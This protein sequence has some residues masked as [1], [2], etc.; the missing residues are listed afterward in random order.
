MFLIRAHINPI[1][2][3]ILWDIEKAIKKV[4]FLFSFLHKKFIK[5]IY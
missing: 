1:F 4:V 3:N 5:I 2:E